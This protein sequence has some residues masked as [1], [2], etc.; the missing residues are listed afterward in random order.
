MEIWR[1]SALALAEKAIE[2]DPDL[3]EGYRLRGNI[4]KDG[5]GMLDEY[6]KDIEEAYR[7]APGDAEVMSSLGILYINEGKYREGTSLQLKAF[8]GS[9]NKKDPVYYY[10]WGIA[11]RDVGEYKK[12]EMLYE[13]A[14][15]LDPGN[16]L[17]Y[18]RLGVLYYI[19][20]EE[21][22]K[23]IDILHEGLKISPKYIRIISGLGWCYR[24][25]GDLDKAEEY[26]SKIP[27]I[28]DEFEDTT[29][30]FPFRHRLG[31]VKWLKGEKEEAMR[32][33]QEQ[34]KLDHE[35]RM[36]LR[37]Y[38]NWASKTYYYDLGV[39]NAFLGNREE[40]YLWLDSALNFGWFELFFSEQDPMLDGIRQEESFQDMVSI[41]RGKDLEARNAVREVLYQPEFMNQIEWFFKED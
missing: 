35:T 14:I 1:D 24:Q 20:M 17:F 9:T 15:R 10:W 29:Q 32:L 28:E 12:A 11:F 13:Q 16:F 30:Y 3:A 7:L 21:Y 36:G 18:E 6:R 5:F 31:H 27:S 22:H 23:A 33:F 39:V 34:M 40:A 37:G 2:I 41:K 38:G 19:R 8:I 4:K 25:L 26:Y